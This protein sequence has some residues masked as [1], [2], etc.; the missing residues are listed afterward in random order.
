MRPHFEENNDF[1]FRLAPIR[2]AAGQVVA[3]V[4]T[5]QIFCCEVTPEEL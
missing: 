2:D 4:A 5:R 1:R 3:V